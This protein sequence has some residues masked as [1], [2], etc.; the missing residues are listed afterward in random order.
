MRA[1]PSFTEERMSYIPNPATKLD[2]WIEMV[3]PDGHVVRV[4]HTTRID[5]GLAWQNA[6]R[7]G[8]KFKVDVDAEKA[9]AAPKGK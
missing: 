5:S 6:L 8:F 2:D 7:K 3:R 4:P 9:A 1:R